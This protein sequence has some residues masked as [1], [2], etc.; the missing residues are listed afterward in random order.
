MGDVCLACSTRAR[1]CASESCFSLAPPDLLFL[2]FADI[3]SSLPFLSL[4]VEDVVEL[5]E[6][7]VGLSHLPPA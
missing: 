7:E 1:S 5:A 3:L 4:Q 6:P 2:S